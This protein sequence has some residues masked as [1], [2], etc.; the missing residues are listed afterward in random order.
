MQNL[1]FKKKEEQKKKTL[2][3]QK[4][5]ETEDLTKVSLHVACKCREWT[6]KRQGKEHHPRT[7]VGLSWLDMHVPNCY[8]LMSNAIWNTV[9]ERFAFK[10]PYYFVFYACHFLMIKS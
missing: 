7:R 1:R 10:N 8:T 2:P 5:E 3:R 4:Y 9:P 6:Q